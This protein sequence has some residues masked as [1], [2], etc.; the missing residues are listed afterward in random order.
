MSSEAEKESPTLMKTP[1]DKKIKTKE[2]LTKESWLKKPDDI[3]AHA[4]TSFYFYMH[5]C[6]HVKTIY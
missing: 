3:T 5:F 4:I 1:D 6:N 2:L